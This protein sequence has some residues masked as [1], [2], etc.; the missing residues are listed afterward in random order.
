[1]RKKIVIVGVIILV[2]GLVLA[3][4]G[5]SIARTGISIATYSL[6]PGEGKTVSLR[7]GI[8]TVSIAYNGSTPP[9][10]V[11][12][13]KVVESSSSTKAEA[14]LING[15][16]PSVYVED[17]SSVPILVDIAVTGI[18]SSI[19]V[20]GLMFILGIILFFVGLGITIYGFIRRG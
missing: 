12:K 17:N 3:A 5:F 15:T 9:K 6:S 11:I 2:I 4:G 1:M 20:A 10:I 8:S 14:F 13:G 19:E 16:S 7:S 18:S